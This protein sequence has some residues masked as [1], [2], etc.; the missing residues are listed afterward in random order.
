MNISLLTLKGAR[1]RYLATF[2][3][4]QNSTRKRTTL[5]FFLNFKY[6]LGQKNTTSSPGTSPLSKWRGRGRN[7]RTRRGNKFSDGVS[8]PFH[9]II[10]KYNY[11]TDYMYDYMK[12]ASNSMWEFVSRARQPNTPRIVEY[13]ATR[14]TMIWGFQMLFPVIGNHVSFLAI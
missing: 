8:D 5:K 11:M 1:S 14:N 10:L 2:S 4:N 3:F 9:V 12:G 7:C 13:F 6:Q